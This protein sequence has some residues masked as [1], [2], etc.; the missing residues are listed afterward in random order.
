MNELLQ[1]IST[2]QLLHFIEAEERLEFLFPACSQQGAQLARAIFTIMIGTSAQTESFTVSE[3]RVLLVALCPRQLHSL[4][5][6]GALLPPLLLF[7]F[8]LTSALVLWALT[9]KILF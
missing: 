5:L 6:C 3:T 9:L 8:S 1:G 4:V 7:L 2:L